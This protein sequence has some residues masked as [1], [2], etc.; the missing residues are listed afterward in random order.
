MLVTA[1]PATESI[2]KILTVTRGRLGTEAVAHDYDP[3]T[4][5]TEGL[6][7]QRIYNICP[8]IK[9]SSKCKGKNI[10]VKFENQKGTLDSF[11]IQY[12]DKVGK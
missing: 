2:I 1:Q 4:Q 9:L 11:A 3:T 7:G 10:E 12:I 6:E 5:D 8:I